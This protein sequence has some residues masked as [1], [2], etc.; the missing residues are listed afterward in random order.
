MDLLLFNHLVII[1]FFDSFNFHFCCIMFWCFLLSIF[2]ASGA[3][4]LDAFGRSIQ[5]LL[6]CFEASLWFYLFLD[7]QRFLLKIFLNRMKFFGI[8]FLF[9]IFNRI[10]FIYIE[11]LLILWDLII[12]YC[13]ICWLILAV[14]ISY[15]SLPSLIQCRCQFFL[16]ITK[17]LTA[18]IRVNYDDYIP[19]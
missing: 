17:F 10:D 15:L 9:K 3:F 11:L 2:L 8:W 18:S 5:A 13:L 16:G 14:V 19:G 4:V 6:W 12:I 1:I 7:I